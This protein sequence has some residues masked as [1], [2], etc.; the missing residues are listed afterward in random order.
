M[1]PNLF[2][3]QG[4]IPQVTNAREGDAM[5]RLHVTY[6]TVSD[7]WLDFRVGGFRINLYGLVYLEKEMK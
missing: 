3:S 6:F 4:G 1:N 2:A 7:R 5:H